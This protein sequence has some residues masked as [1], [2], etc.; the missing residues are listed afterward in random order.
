MIPNNHDYLNVRLDQLIGAVKLVYASTFLQ[1]PRSYAKNTLHRTEEEKMAVVIQRLTGA[2]YGDYFY[3]AV[4]GVAQSYNFYPI[5]PMK[6]EHGI[7]HIAL[8]FGRTVVEGASALRFSPRHSRLMPHF[9][10]V[11]DILTHAQRSFYAMKLTG[12][13]RK[14]ES[15]RQAADEASLVRLEVS[16][17]AGIPTHSPVRRL[18]S[19]YSPDD[20]RI[21]DRTGGVGYPLI[22]FAS[23]LKF[24]T[25]P[26]SDILTQM[27]EIGEKGMA[28]PVELEF[29]VH[30]PDNPKHTPEFTLLQIRPMALF[31]QTVDIDIQSREVGDAFCFSTL[32]LGHGNYSHI[33]DIVFV[34]P[35]TFDPAK[36]VDIAREVG[37]I[38]KK[39]MPEERKYVL[40]GPGRWGSADRWLGIPVTWNEISGVGCI[41]ET[42]TEQL[43]ADPSQG[44]HFFHNIT[45]LGISYLTITENSE[46]FVDWT[47]LMHLTIQHRTPHLK[48]A[49]LDEPLIIKI[50]GKRSRGLIMKTG[51]NRGKQ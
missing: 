13:P 10:T 18:S 42:R 5:A 34:D 38:N 27:L 36:T 11:D 21:R 46:D 4:S 49:R 41:I 33:R 35:D 37:E 47:W 31:Q 17:A 12:F 51:I 22:T 19:T 16:E 40:I 39:L 6:G 32:T 1:A 44:S 14:I 9:S 30:L 24:N 48:H 43:R 50:D 20:H 15:A 26:L 7:A 29:A 25:F 28:S 8:G 23:I 3:P 2:A 45:S